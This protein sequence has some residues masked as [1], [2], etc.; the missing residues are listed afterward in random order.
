M[1]IDGDGIYEID[2]G[3]LVKVRRGKY[4]AIYREFTEQF[5][6]TP[7]EASMVRAVSSKGGSGSAGVLVR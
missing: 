5:G 6:V 2:L 1:D 4:K 7:T 3:K